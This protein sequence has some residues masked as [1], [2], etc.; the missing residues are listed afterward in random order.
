MKIVHISDTHLGSSTYRKLSADGFNQREVDIC[1]AFESAISK[2]I[3]EIKP[4][5]VLHCGDLFDVVKPTNRILNFGIKQI[6]RLVQA[7]IRTVVISGNHDS[8]KQ[9]YMGS[10]F[11]IFDL[12]AGSIEDKEVLKIYYKNEY[13]TL[14]IE[15]IT[16]HIIPQ[17]ISDDIFKAE[18]LKLSPVKG[19]KNILM[20]HAGVAGMEEFAHGDF[21]ELLVDPKYFEG[22]DYVA[23]GHHHGLQKI[24]GFDN[25]AYS[26][27]TERLSFNEVCQ[28]KGFIELDSNDLPKIKP[29]FL[30]NI[31]IMREL[32]PIDASNKDTTQIMEEIEAAIKSFD[33][34][35][36]I[37]RIKINNIEP[38]I[39]ENINDRQIREWA[40]GALHFEPL[41]E[42]AAKAGE[43]AEIVKPSIGGIKEEFV[44]YINA[45]N[46]LKA[47]DLDFYKAKGIEYIEAAIQE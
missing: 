39:L 37:V 42:K 18:L 40:A 30:D 5:L 19:R 11:E 36:K 7:G 31:R 20:L 43:K 23:L 6:L 26:G 17:C 34:K 44:D 41:Y 25:A 15:D 46:S 10:V 32:S 13:K 27:S 16:L 9:K 47:D 38:H 2:I 28:P 4:D 45:Y 1:S 12:V 22:F 21:N 8:P 3:E 33:V 24:R 35:D 14:D 29:H